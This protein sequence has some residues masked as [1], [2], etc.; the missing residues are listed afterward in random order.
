MQYLTFEVEN[1]KE[2]NLLIAIAEKL[3][4]KRYNYSEDVK[5]QPTELKKIYQ[6]IDAGA[7]ISTFGDIKEWQRT[8]RADRNLNF[9]KI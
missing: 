1:G 3:G 5:S 9:D 2:L 4:I 8:T 7:D 6:I